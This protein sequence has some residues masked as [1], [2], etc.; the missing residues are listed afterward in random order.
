MRRA[1]E[2]LEAIGVQ[3]ISPLTDTTTVTDETQTHYRRQL[4]HDGSDGASHYRSSRRLHRT[5]SRQNPPE[6]QE[7]SPK[8]CSDSATQRA[9]E[10]IGRLSFPPWL[11]E[12]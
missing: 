3:P 4:R 7:R 1:N 12:W 5:P 6:L 2:A 8:A 11:Q 9:V 10:A